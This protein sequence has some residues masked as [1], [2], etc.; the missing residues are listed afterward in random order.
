VVLKNIDED[1]DF[2]SI[3]D[4]ITQTS[5]LNI[6]IPFLFLFVAFML[7]LVSLWLAKK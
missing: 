3:I 4:A 1:V 6:P 5:V 2:I 7:I